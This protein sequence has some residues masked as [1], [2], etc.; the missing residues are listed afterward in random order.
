MTRCLIAACDKLRAE[1]FNDIPNEIL[2]N[3][4]TGLI[5]RFSLLERSGT[6]SIC[7]FL[8]PRY[9]LAVFSDA[10]EAKNTKK[11]AQDLL[12]A[13][14]AEDEAAATDNETPDSSVA[15]PEENDKFSPWTILNKI[16]G[17]KQRTGTPLSKAIKEIATYLNDDIL[18]V[19]NDKTWNCPL[20][21]WRNHR[22]TYPNLVQL[23]KRYGNVMA[24]SV[25]S[26]RIFSK[27]GLI[28]NECRTRLTSGKVKQLTFLNVN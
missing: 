28:I 21:W 14:I 16:V 12:M 4:R 2:N 26:E 11:R 27:T 15:P 20:E 19:K 3:L 22:Y 23:F 10:N 6:F 17:T 25:P 13:L 1:D 5:S 7:T 24:T 9:K 18:P 8:D